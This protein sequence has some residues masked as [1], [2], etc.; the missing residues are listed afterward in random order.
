VRARLACAH[1]GSRKIALWHCQ[2]MQGGRLETIVFLLFDCS[3]GVERFLPKHVGGLVV[4]RSNPIVGDS[5]LHNTL[6]CRHLNKA[7]LYLLSYSS[8]LLCLHRTR[9]TVN[10]QE[11]LPETLAASPTESAESH[12]PHVDS[13][14]SRQLLNQHHKASIHLTISSTSHDTS[15]HSSNPSSDP[16][17]PD[18][19]TDASP[20]TEEGGGDIV[21]GPEGRGAAIREWLDRQGDNPEKGLIRLSGPPILNKLREEPSAS[22][23]CGEA[24]Q[25]PKVGSYALCRG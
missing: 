25:I 16:T 10:S 12:G 21:T 22:V 14:H 19:S 6:P 24:L 8:L 2:G 9:S 11:P 20:S 1:A 5:S 23:A 3:V 4:R 13:A 15:R 17:G 7:P 18:P